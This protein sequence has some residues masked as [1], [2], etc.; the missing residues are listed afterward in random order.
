LPIA[1]FLNRNDYFAAQEPKL[2]MGYLPGTH[3]VA[4]LTTDNKGGLKEYSDFQE[5]IDGLIQ[6]HKLQKLG[7]VYHNFSPAGYTGVVCLSESHLSV[8]TWPEHGRINGD[9]YLS[10]YLR[11]NDGTVARIY[12]EIKKHFGASVENETILKR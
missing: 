11:E 6:E 10:N 1:S 5:L 8:H 3:I 4:T 7:E 2:F 9:I 12:D